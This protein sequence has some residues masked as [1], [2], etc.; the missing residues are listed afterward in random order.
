MIASHRRTHR[1]LHAMLWPLLIALCVGAWHARTPDA[2]MTE[3]P[4]FLSS[5]GSGPG[6][7]PTGLLA[8]PDGC[9]PVD[10]RSR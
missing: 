8:G 7:D 10:E 9:A 2:V 4:A 6:P 1:W 5:H 3:W